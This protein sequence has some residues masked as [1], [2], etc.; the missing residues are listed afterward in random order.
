MFSLDHGRRL[1]TLFRTLAGNRDGVWVEAFY[2]AAWYASVSVPEPAHFSRSDG[3]SYYR[4]DPPRPDT[5]FDS[6]VDCDLC[7]RHNLVIG[8]KRSSFPS[9]EEITGELTRLSWFL[10]PYRSII[11]IPED[12]VLTTMDRLADLGGRAGDRV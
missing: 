3:F 5:P 8:R 7:P 10:P 9:D 6:Q 2:N 11:L 12:W 1:E 4:L